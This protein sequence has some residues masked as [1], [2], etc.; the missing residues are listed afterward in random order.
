MHG[1]LGQLG[2]CFM[3]CTRD[4]LQV[5][6]QRFHADV[7]RKEVGETTTSSRKDHDILIH[8][9]IMAVEDLNDMLS[10]ISGHTTRFVGSGRLSRARQPRAVA[11]GSPPVRVGPPARLVG[12]GFAFLVPARSALRLLSAANP[13]VS[14]EPPP[15]KHPAYGRKPPPRSGTLPAAPVPRT[16]D[17]RVRAGHRVLAPTHQVPPRPL[18]RQGVEVPRVEE[19]EQASTTTPTFAPAGVG[20]CTRL[21]EA[22]RT[23][24]CAHER[25]CAGLRLV[26]AEEG[27]SPDVHC[28]PLRPAECPVEESAACRTEKRASSNLCL[29]G[30][31]CGAHP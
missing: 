16:R 26:G 15:L 4:K 30:K 11:A 22:E 17:P 18:A 28:D 3:K 25:R 8:D 31:R 24:I 5:S 14:R 6:F 19:V 2:L 27:R 10:S 1:W 12:S 7:T 23:F 9:L 20:S 21:A 13:T 29:Q